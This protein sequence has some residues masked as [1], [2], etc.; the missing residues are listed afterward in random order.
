MWILHDFFRRIE[1]INDIKNSSLH[2]LNF[3]SDC[4]LWPDH[5]LDHNHMREIMTSLEVEYCC[6]IS[7]N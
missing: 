1:T 6:N 5:A 2:N 3:F 7:I 4:I